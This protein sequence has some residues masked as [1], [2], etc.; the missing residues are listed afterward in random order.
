MKDL[1][2]LD[3]EITIRSAFDRDIKNAKK[4]L[5]AADLPVDDLDSSMLAFVAEADGLLVAAIGIEVFD[6]V[7]LLRSLVVASDFRAAGIGRF[8]VERLEDRARQD[9]VS[10]LWL[11]TIDADAWFEGLG[12]TAL[13]REQAPDAIRATAEF[14][15][16]CP[17]DAVLMRKPL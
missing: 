17:D 4:L 10:E 1:C 11:L 5:R 12:Y 7:G 16:L 3:V 14:S 8:L 2:D 6:S 9:G 13:G 15:S